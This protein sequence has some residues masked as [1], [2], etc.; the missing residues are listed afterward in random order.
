MRRIGLL[1]GSFDPIHLGHLAMAKQAK[2][3]L[4]LDEVWFVL[5]RDT[6][7]KASIATCYEIRLHM[8]KI[9]IAPYRNFHACTIERDGAG[10]NY[11]IDTIRKL[12]QAYPENQYFF[13]LG[14]DQVTQLP[15]WKAI[16]ELASLVRFCCFERA[17]S[18]LV[19]PYPISKLTMPSY[20]IS[21]SAI[22]DGQLRYLDPKVK[23]FIVYH[24]LYEG[25]VSSYMQEERWQHSKRV[26]TLASQLAK[27][28]QYDEKIAY[29]C[30]I[31]HD[32]NKEFRYVS[33]EQSAVILKHLRP[34]LLKKPQSLWHGFMG[35][36]VCK[37]FLGIYD[38]RIL[39]AVE[40][41]ILGNH[42]GVYTKLLYVADKLEVGRKYDTQPMIAIALNDIHK[43][44]EVVKESQRAFYGKEF[45][46]E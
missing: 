29:L 16:D 1:G 17:G 8:L 3:Q 2:R 43:G 18:D 13:L 26:A 41:H 46:N 23:Q 38:E 10:K 37:H 7:L 4:Q 34:A 42:Q 6:P 40:H 39:N 24:V 30:G 45:V 19:S 32:I 25:I 12:K 20:P 44:F 35:R 21:S 9:T 28:N 5:S 15:K 11:T 27:A 22:R 33:L 14:G 36:Y 31:Y